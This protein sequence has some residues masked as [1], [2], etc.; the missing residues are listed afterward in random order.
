LAG[1]D[2]KKHDSL[3]YLGKKARS[4]QEKKRREGDQ[5][6]RRKTR[7]RSRE[8]DRHYLASKGTKEC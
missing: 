4:H 3:P 7:A 8:G 5:N 1:F 6:F 2:A